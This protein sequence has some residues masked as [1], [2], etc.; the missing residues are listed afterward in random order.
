REEVNL[1]AVRLEPPPEHWWMKTLSAAV[2][3][4][5]FD[6]YGGENRWFGQY[7]DLEDDMPMGRYAMSDMSRKLLVSAFDYADIARRRREN[8]A[9]LDEALSHLAF[10]PRLPEG[11]VPL[12]FPVRLANRDEMLRRLYAQRIYPPV[13][14]PFPG[15]LPREYVESYRLQ[16]HIMMLICDQRC[17]PEEM[18]R[19][20][21]LLRADAMPAP[22]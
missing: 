5:E 9:I 8:Y 19:T 3:R 21:D 16:S 13:H 7:Q 4:R 11:V 6:I 10:Y 15:I 1:S 2:L 22:S 17:G 14:W 12:G 18:R 20:I